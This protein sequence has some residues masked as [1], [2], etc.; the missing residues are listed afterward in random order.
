MTDRYAVYEGHWIHTN[1]DPTVPRAMV[2]TLAAWL[3]FEH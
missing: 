3:S 2:L 1:L